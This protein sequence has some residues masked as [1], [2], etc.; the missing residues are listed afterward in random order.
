MT[1][2]TPKPPEIGAK[3]GSLPS[4]ADGG[5]IDFGAAWLAFRRRW[6]AFATVFGI[7]MLGAITAYVL[8]PRR[9]TA[10]AQVVV[11]T[12][13]ER[14]VSQ[15]VVSPQTPDTYA[16]DTA[17]QIIQ[18]PALASIVAKRLGLGSD[19]DFMPPTKEIPLTPEQANGVATGLV[20]SGLTASRSGMAFVINVNFT[21]RDPVI[22]AKVANELVKVY[23]DD[24]LRSKLIATQQASGFLHGKLDGLRDKAVRAEAEL[25]KFKSSHPLLSSTDDQNISQQQL[26]SMSASLS[27]A[28]AEYAGVSAELQKARS[29]A[30]S[31]DYAPQD[32]A[33]GSQANGSPDGLNS[34]GGLW[35][36][37]AVLSRRLAELETS[38]GPNHPSLIAVRSEL[39]AIRSRVRAA[40]SR[41]VGEIEAREKA[42]ASRVASLQASVD[43]LSA[44][45]NSNNNAKATQSELV[46]EANTVAGTYEDYLRRYRESSAQEGS[47]SA[48]VRILTLA[49]IPG[50]AS[51]PSPLTFAAAGL[52]IGMLLGTAVIFLLEL[53]E[54]G[55]R[56]SADVEKIFGLR[57]LA[58]VPSYS[59]TLDPEEKKRNSEFD[60]RVVIDRPFSAFT[61]SFR[62]LLA[63][64]HQVTNVKPYQVVAVTSALPGEGKSTSAICLAR[65]AAQTGLRTLLIDCDTRRPDRGPA[66]QNA[67]R[68]LLEVLAGTCSLKQAVI[69]D[70]ISSAYFLPISTQAVGVNDVLTNASMDGLLSELRKLFDFIIIDTAPVLAIAETRVLVTKADCVLYLVRWGDTPGSAS[71]AGAKMLEESGA[72]VAGVVLTQ[73]DLNTQEKW[74]KSDPSAY[75]KK[76]K[77]YY[78]Q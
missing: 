78:T 41:S 72:N 50:G 28:R 20:T 52:V 75:Y 56:T 19:P 45:L 51:F 38:V 37:E 66:S 24:Q 77:K 25:A 33:A 32:S 59:S 55:I 54:K 7:V 47:Q 69:Q 26:A 64:L 5:L 36:Q 22:A 40:G 29:L 58:A 8:V 57:T 11:K 6:V 3:L 46:R 1:F 17:V 60:P 35:G 18:S 70:S 63:S 53:L 68:G 13:R 73:V 21:A 9:Y 15:E 34:G 62:M 48:D 30:S 61:E 74:T 31:G 16:V 39:A 2:L 71:V 42:A 76:Y 49:G 10:T 12:G 23:A 14:I 44:A 43:S 4:T 27:A 65:V 67:P